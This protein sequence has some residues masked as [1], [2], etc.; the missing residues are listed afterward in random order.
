MPYYTFR[1]VDSSLSARTLAIGVDSYKSI[2]ASK[3]KAMD[4]FGIV[5]QSAISYMLVYFW[6]DN[7]EDRFYI[8]NDDNP[9][10]VLAAIGSDS[11]TLVRTTDFADALINH[12]NQ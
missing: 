2:E 10:S 8:F 11:V 3:T 12:F 7:G 6:K 4:L 5:D 9:T 1:L